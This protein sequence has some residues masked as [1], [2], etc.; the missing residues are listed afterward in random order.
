MQHMDSMDSDKRKSGLSLVGDLPWGTHFCQFYQSPEDLLGI[1][2]PFCKAGLDNNELCVWV[3]PGLQGSRE[4][5]QALAAAIPGFQ[6]Y[7]DSGQMEVV[8][9]GRWLGKTSES[10][11]SMLSR[12]DRAVRSGFDGLRLARV[13]SPGTGSRKTFAPSADTEAMAGLNAVAAFA[14]PRDEFD[15]VGLMEVVKRHRFALVRNAGRWEVIESSEATVARDALRRSEE[16]LQSLFS[17]MAEGFA[18]HRIVLDGQGKPCDYVFLQ[19]NDAFERLTG[20]KREDIIGKLVTQVM[21]G[22][23]KDPAAWIDRYGAVALTGSPAHFQSYSEPLGKWYAVSAFSPQRG[24]FAVTFSDITDN[25]RSEDEL[26]KAKTEWERTFDSV[27]DLIAILDGRH[28]VVR[29]NRAMAERLGVTPEQCIGLHCYEAVHGTSG[30]PAFC[31]HVQTCRDGCQHVADVY[32]PRLGGHFLVSTTPLFD[33]RGRL[34]GSVH[35]AR[36]ITER[37]KSEEALKQR[38]MDLEAAN[39]EVASFSYTVSHDLRAPLRSMDGYAQA[40]IEDYGDKLDEQGRE[41]LGNI[42]SASQA[43]GQLINDILGL[44]RVV[45]VELKQERLD[46]SAMALSVAESLQKAEPGRQVQ[47]AIAPGVEAWGDAGLVRM[48]LENLLGNA[49]KFT[50]QRREA[51]IEFGMTRQEGRAAF[52]VR[53]NGAGFNMAYV[54]KLFQPFQRLHSGKEFPGTGIGLAT[55]QR[56]IDRHGGEAW[57][58]GKVGEGATFYFTLERGEHTANDR[59]DHTAGRR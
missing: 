39:K 48:V 53:D 27:P 7:V 45:R 43:M 3:A 26:R 36:D 6:R 9:A 37:K 51:R 41:W 50:S 49:F 40:L 20:L 30:P 47:L 2:I 8:P 54:Q 1:L 10:E 55:V 22:I 29:A 35:V 57:A 24:F 25:K 59:E 33:G 15:A 46:L 17:N 58:E 38:T 5:G 31:P 42:R 21:P 12:L 13:F 19:V 16:K 52:F 34:D 18:Y 14:Y 56:V 11:K 4:A 32:E 23:E 28:R 44:S